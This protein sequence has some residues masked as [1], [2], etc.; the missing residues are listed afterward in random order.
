MNC[1]EVLASM[2][3]VVKVLSGMDF[4]APSYLILM[5]GEFPLPRTATDTNGGAQ[6]PRRTAALIIDAGSA[7]SV[8]SCVSRDLPATSS[9]KFV[10]AGTL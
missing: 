4:N 8:G 1:L 2:R 5:R 10:A 6:T 3:S 7:D 9:M